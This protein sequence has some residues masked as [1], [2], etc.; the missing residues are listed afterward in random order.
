L[1]SPAVI[2]WSQHMP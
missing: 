2:F 1:L